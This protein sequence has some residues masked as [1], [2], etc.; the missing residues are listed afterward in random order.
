MHFI[1][2]IIYDFELIFDLHVSSHLF[3][4][5]YLIKSL[6]KLGVKFFIHYARRFILNQLKKLG[7][8]LHPLGQSLCHF[9]WISLLKCVCIE[10]NMAMFA[11][12]SAEKKRLSRGFTIGLAIVLKRFLL[13]ITSIFYC[14][15]C[16]FSI[17][18]SL[19]LLK[20]SS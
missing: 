8:W 4:F 5:S 20:C 3:F 6:V 2:I 18:Q 13:Q 9:H 10:W 12:C 7:P 16:S 15:W 11:I 19:K 1:P 17:I 14:G